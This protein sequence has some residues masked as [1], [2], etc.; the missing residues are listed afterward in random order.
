MG[1]RYPKYCE[2]SSFW[3]TQ[4]TPDAPGET[5]SSFGD[6]WRWD[7]SS[8]DLLEFLSCYFYSNDVFMFLATKTVVAV[9]VVVVVVGGGGGGGGG[10]LVVVWWWFGGVGSVLLLWSLVP[11]SFRIG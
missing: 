3:S 4:W 1:G 10:G 2:S 5:S 11:R 6:S 7:G 9:V 8:D